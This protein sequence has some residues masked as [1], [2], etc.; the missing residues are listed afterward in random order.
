MKLREIF[1]DAPAGA[2]S[3]GGFA[4]TVAKPWAGKNNPSQI[5]VHH[6]KKVQLKHKD[7]KVV[8]HGK[9]KDVS[10][11]IED[12]ETNLAGEYH[13]TDNNGKIIQKVRFA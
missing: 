1:E 7:G 9:W 11:Y 8:S 12:N 10:K 5:R 4:R 2:I 6:N 3:T 13:I